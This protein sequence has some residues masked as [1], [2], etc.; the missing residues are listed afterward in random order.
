[1]YRPYTDTHYFHLYIRKLV[2]IKLFTVTTVVPL[3][4]PDFLGAPVLD[5]TPSAY[6]GIRTYACAYTTSEKVNM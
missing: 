6:P 2:T 3:S 5:S 1:M 4:K